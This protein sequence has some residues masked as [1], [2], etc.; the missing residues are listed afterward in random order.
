MVLLA[1][2]M[3]AVLTHDRAIMLFGV[4]LYSVTNVAQFC[5]RTYDTNPYPQT[6]ISNPCDAPC[7]YRG[8]ANEEHAAGVPVVAIL[9]DS[10]IDI[11]DVAI[12]KVFVARYAMADYVIH[13]CANRFRKA[14]VIQ[15]CGYCL[16]DVDDVIM[17]D[18]VEFPGGDA[19]HHVWSN[20]IQHFS[21]KAPC[22]THFFYLIRGFDCD[23][24]IHRLFVN[25]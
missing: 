14:A 16:L 12:F 24:H 7:W 13:R 10:N 9:N 20:H 23:A 18:L 15:G 6:F 25:G 22:N 21:C 19:C 8:V 17:T 4:C 2:T 1:N 5:T 11:D 3:S